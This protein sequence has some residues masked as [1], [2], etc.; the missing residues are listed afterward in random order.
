MFNFFHNLS[1]R[2]KFQII[3]FAVTMI[4]TLY[5]RWLASNALE[6][7]VA[8]AKQGNAPVSVIESLESAH[9]AFIFHA[10]WESGIEFVIQFVL[11]FFVASFF[12]RPIRELINAF[13]EVE[14]GNL[15]KRVDVAHKD[16]IGE[17]GDHFNS[18]T[19]N[20]RSILNKVDKSARSMGQS[21]FQITAVSREITDIG[22]RE[23]QGSDDVRRVTDRLVSVSKAVQSQAEST[24]EEA[25]KMSEKAIEGVVM[26]EDNLSVMNE[27][28]S[29]VR[30]A[31][32]EVQDLSQTATKI[33]SISSTITQIAEQTNL[34][35]LNAAIEAARAGEHGRGFAVV[36]D[37]VRLLAS[38]TA[39]S[40]CEI[41]DIIGSLQDGVSNAIGAMENVAKQ[42]EI[43]GASAKKTSTMIE[44]MGKDVSN[45]VA[46]GEVIVNQSAEQIDSLSDLQQTLAR[47]FEA[48]STNA[49]KT[50]VTSEIGAGLHEVTGELEEVIASFHFKEVTTFKKEANELR[51]HPRIN[52]K[53][54]VQVKQSDQFWEGLTLDISLSGVK[55]QLS[56]PLA[57]STG[58]VDF[59]MYMPVEDQ[60]NFEYQE[61]LHLN[62]MIQWHREETG[63]YLYGLEFIDASDEDKE[64]ISNI[65][66]YFHSKATYNE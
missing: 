42:V 54:M 59:T 53:Q 29:G 58:P 3:F 61:Q 1:I 14:S 56:S 41:A 36:A 15:L 2:W 4:T 27:V 23:Q 25:H 62:T 28:I 43:S 60:T 64:R 48:L 33:S 18:M 6:N 49:S 44:K 11:I 37:E 26:V 24:S 9:E 45:V 5:N 32:D 38:N 47:L 10:V 50:E 52:C 35:A 13:Y 65:F 40:S 63:K 57:E 51:G 30:V 17:L 31:T 22:K 7:S 12:V 55:I 8:I 46:D 21:A 39:K 66:T 19:E 16:E 20:L 34:L